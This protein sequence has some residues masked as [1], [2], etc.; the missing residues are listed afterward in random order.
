MSSDSGM[1]VSIELYRELRRERD[2][3]QVQLEEARTHG[4][5]QE[6]YV[7][8]LIHRIEQNGA[9]FR[10]LERQIDDEKA[11]GDRWRDRA[12]A[13]GAKAPKAVSFPG[14]LVP[15]TSPFPYEE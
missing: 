14:L 13:A 2:N 10:E 1:Y 4:R 12:V 3:L 7:E 8:R 6:G 9:R 11:R 15:K 5:E